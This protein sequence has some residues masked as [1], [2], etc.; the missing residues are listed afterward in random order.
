LLRLARRLGRLQLFAAQPITNRPWATYAFT[1]TPSA[2]MGRL[3]F[4][5]PGQERLLATLASRGYMSGLEGI[6]WETVCTVSGGQL[7][8]DRDTSETGTFS[9]PWPV[10]GHGQFVLS[11]SSLIERE[12]P[13]SLPVELAR[14]TVNRLRN[15]ASAWELAGLTLLPGLDDRIRSATVALARAATT[16]HDPLVAA[17]HSTIAL[18]VALGAIVQLGELYSQQALASRRLAGPL[19]T[20]LACRLESPPIGKAAEKIIDAFNSI[21]VPFAWRNVETEAGQYSWEE[22]D[23]LIDWAN[24]NNLRVCGGPLLQLDARTLPDWLYLWE[25]DWEEL[26]SY[27]AS[28]VNAVVERYRSRVQLWNVAARINVPGALKIDEEHTLRLTV[29]A[30]DMVRSLDPRTPV[31]VSFDQPWSEHLAERDRDL[32]PTHFADTLARSEL[33]VA[34]F[35]LEFNWGYW[36]Q[37]TPPRDLVE[38]S[39]LIDRWS[40]LG[41]PLLVS[42]VAPSSGA[43]DPQARHPAAPLVDEEAQIPSPNWQEEVVERCFPVLLAKN[44]VQAIVWNQWTDTHPHEFAHGGLIDASGKAKPALKSLAHLRRKYLD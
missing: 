30:V 19:A 20:L 2:S 9:I 24:E 10:A 35:G 42:F 29:E 31:I 33:G 15:Q 38:L 18:R 7:I 1:F 12:E 13:Y 11:T 34:G 43:V 22:Y 6:P 40:A 16:Q 25:D 8:V 27:F 32:P 39:R 37:G 41:H 14:G 5:A 26:Q 44:S 21:V 17:R 36:P 28:W 4:I 3:R 23:Q